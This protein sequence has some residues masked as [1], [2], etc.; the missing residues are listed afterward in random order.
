MTQAEVANDGIEP[1]DRKADFGTFEICQ[2]V[3]ELS[4]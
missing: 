1:S 4:A 2:P 3:P